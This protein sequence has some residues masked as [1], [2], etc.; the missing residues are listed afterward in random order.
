VYFEDGVDVVL[1]FW[2]HETIAVQTGRRILHVRRVAT[3]L[4]EGQAAVH[5]HT[6]PHVKVGGAMCHVGGASGEQPYLGHAELSLRLQQ[7]DALVH[8]PD[9]AQGAGSGPQEEPGPPRREL[10]LRGEPQGHLLRRRRRRSHWVRAHGSEHKA[11]RRGANTT[12]KSMITF[13]TNY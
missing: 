6:H 10:L 1:G 8:G 12:F 11:K 9:R 13:C 7:Q 2:S 4:L 3:Q 5:L